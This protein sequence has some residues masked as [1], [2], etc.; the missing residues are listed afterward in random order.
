V[1][2][3]V[4]VENGYIQI[5]ERPGLGID[6]NLDVAAEHPYSEHNFLPLFQEGWERRTGS[7]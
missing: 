3:P 1:D 4:V 5:P 7:A 6:L 2:Y